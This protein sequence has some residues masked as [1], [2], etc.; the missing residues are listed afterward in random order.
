MSQREKILAIG[1]AAVLVLVGGQLLVNKYRAAKQSRLARIESLDDRIFEARNRMLEG[2][3]ADRMFGEYLVRSLPSDGQI[4][5]SDYQRWL[6]E[7]TALLNMANTNVTPQGTAVIRDPFA[8]DGTSDE[9]YVRHTFK[10]TGTTDLEG[11]IDL[12]YMFYTKDYLHRIRDLTVSPDRQQGGLKLDV[13]IDAI[14]LSAAAEDLEPPEH[15]SPLVGDYDDYAQAILNRNFFSPPNQPPRFTSPS[16][17]TANVGQPA[18]LSLEAD[19]PEEGRLTYRIVGEA[20]SGLDIDP[21]TGE[22]QWQPDAIGDYTIMVEVEDDGYPRRRDEK[23]LTLAVIDAPPSSDSELAAFDDATQTVLTGLVQGGGDWTAW[24]KVRTQG[25]TLQLRPGDRFEIG[26]LSGT[27]VDV[28]ARFATLEIDGHRFE[29][30][31]AGNLAEAAR[32]AR[33]AEEP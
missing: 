3:E 1:V 14:G 15:T 28:N 27:V 12:L 23:Q 21:Q 26:R 8:T 5:R 6:L 29:L 19:D 18:R 33:S 22:I 13:S 17:M 30:R 20:P 2:A 11:W 10:L 4:A 25:K 24:M 16:R 7:V 9:L 31:P 32:T